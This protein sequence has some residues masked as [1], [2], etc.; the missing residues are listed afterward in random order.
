MQR[1]VAS[2]RQG[3][4]PT[5]HDGGSLSGIPGLRGPGRFAALAVIA[6]L[7][8]RAERAVR[9]AGA[10]G[11]SAMS[12]PFPT[13]EAAQTQRQW[14]IIDATGCTLGRVSTIAARIL[15]GKNKASFTPFI[16]TGD[17]LVVVNCERAR[18]TGRKETDKL[19][20]W[21]TG[22]PGGFRERAAGKLRADNPVRLVE[23]AI[24]GM[25]PKTRLGRAMGR[26]LK[27]YTGPAHP[28]AA[29]NPQ[30]VD[31]ANARRARA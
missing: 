29:Q 30:P 5:F 18:L 23:E 16:D 7:P 4:P 28:H 17:F 9:L 13:V 19:Y 2:R 26:K 1:C 8:D 24:R 15:S 27:V 10:K 31:V 20:R 12:T 21:H 14:W 6:S 25:L 3:C 11:Q 22:Y